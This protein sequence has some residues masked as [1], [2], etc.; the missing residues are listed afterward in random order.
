[1]RLNS[2]WKKVLLV[3]AVVPL[4]ACSLA[5]LKGGPESSS[6][7]GGSRSSGSSSAFSP[8]SDARKDLGDAL[9]KL[10]T[11][12][13]YRL[14]ETTSSTVDGQTVGPTYTRVADFTAA[15]RSHVKISGGSGS[16]MEMIHFGDK[17]YW[18]SD[19]KWSENA[20]QSA[21][22]KAKRGA[23]LEKRLAEATK[24]VKYVGPETVNGVPCFAYTFSL[25]MNEEGHTWAGTGK[26]WVGAADGLPHQIDSEFNV[27]KYGHKSHIVYEYNVDVKVEKPAM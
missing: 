20:G 19:G 24:E 7:G 9:R 1:M 4:S 15:D 17:Q 21:E 18:Y 8:S 25:E 11:A 12:Y 16:D 14:T 2:K 10:K 27:S 5:K 23:E 13:P 26:A 6:N 22:E 3:L